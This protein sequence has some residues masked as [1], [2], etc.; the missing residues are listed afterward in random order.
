MA[1][2]HKHSTLDQAMV[3][4]VGSD[5]LEANFAKTCKTKS[6]KHEKAGCEFAFKY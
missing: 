6:D 1:H 4:V 2:L 3:S 5:I